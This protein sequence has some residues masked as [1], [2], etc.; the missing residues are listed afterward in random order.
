MSSTTE[1]A[2]ILPEGHP[3]A[4][5]ASGTLHRLSPWLLALVVFLAFL[6]VLRNDFTNYDDDFYVTDNPNTS[7]GLTWE[8]LKW[9]FTN[10]ESPTWHPLTWLSHAL[11]AQVFGLRPW[12]HH[13]TSLCLHAANT[14][15]LFFLLKR[16]TRTHYRS[17]LV[18]ALFGLHPM[19]VESVAWISE[20]KDLL[21]ALFFFLTLWAYCVFATTPPEEAKAGMAQ[22]QHRRHPRRTVTYLASVAFFILGLLSKP[23]VVTLPFVLLL[24]DYW[25]LGRLGPVAQTATRETNAPVPRTPRLGSLLLEKTPFFCLSLAASVIVL[26][27]QK[28][29]GA[30]ASLMNLSLLAR[31]ENASV[32]YVRYV[33]KLAFPTGLNAF[34]P[35]PKQWPAYAA[36]GSVALLTVVSVIFWRARR[37]FPWALAGWLWFLGTLVPVIGFVQVGWQSIAD[38]YTYLPSIGL[39]IIVGWGLHAWAQVKVGRKPASIALISLALLTCAGLTWRQ[40]GYWANS[41]VL[42]ERALAIEPNNAIALFQLG[43]DELRAHRTPEAAIPHFRAALRLEPKLAQAH[44]QLGSALFLKRDTEEAI[45]ELQLALQLNPGLETAHFNL[46][47][48]LRSLGQNEQALD[49]FREALRLKPFYPEAHNGMGAT[50]ATLGDL[51]GAI[52][53]FQESLKLD[54]NSASTHLNLAIAFEA[55]NEKTKAIQHL[56][57]A[58]KLDPGQGQA[59]R[60]LKVL[61]GPRPEPGS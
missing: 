38:R 57:Q 2:P 20:R 21:S 5:I 27:T 37:K 45:A 43:N 39:F 36:L 13:L 7:N 31:F 26:L 23:M 29:A 6:P 3:P 42:F 4:S 40:A 17:L 41:A 54:P 28:S 30:V 18:A 61:Q 34:Y 32:S 22:P 52:E 46:G 11:D 44:A 55:K 10:R 59:L 48:A 47:V 14:L 53:H 56:Q 16:L 15:V 33:S 60:R 24:L 58:L 25:P 49:H 50:L 35:Q 9:A 1:Q 19:H 12:G 51:A 8:G